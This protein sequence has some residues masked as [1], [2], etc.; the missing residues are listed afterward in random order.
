VQAAPVRFLA[1]GLWEALG[2]AATAVALRYEARRPA[3][4]RQDG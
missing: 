4:R 3:A 2:A 1:V